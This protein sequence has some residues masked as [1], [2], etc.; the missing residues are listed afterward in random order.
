MSKWTKE[1]GDTVEADEVIV[2][3]ETD[4]VSVDIRA[5]AAGKITSQLVKEGDTIKVGDSLAEIDTAAAA[6]EEA[7]AGE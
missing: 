7:A 3:I 5:P 2:I 6:E 1:V 4:K